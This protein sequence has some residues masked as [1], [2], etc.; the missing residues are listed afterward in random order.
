MRLALLIVCVGPAL[1]IVAARGG[2]G[3]TARI[4]RLSESIP[5]PLAAA[6]S[7]EA[8]IVAVHLAA[9]IL[10][11]PILT[12][13]ATNII[14]SFTRA[15]TH[16]AGFA[17][18]AAGRCLRFVKRLWT[19][20]GLLPPNLAQ[21]ALHACMKATGILPIAPCC[22][23]TFRAFSML[24]AFALTPAFA[25][26]DFTMLLLPAI[27]RAAPL[28]LPAL[29]AVCEQRMPGSLSRRSVTDIARRTRRFLHHQLSLRG[30]LILLASMLGRGALSRN[31][32]L[33]RSM[34]FNL[35]MVPMA[36]E[37]NFYQWLLVP[38]SEEERHRIYARLHERHAP[39]VLDAIYDL[40]GYP[41]RVQTLRLKPSSCILPQSG[42]AA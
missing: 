29:A 26:V 16:F 20:G 3:T 32:G 34:A 37:Y 15:M 33:S 5:P 23:A 19:G 2:R 40:R 1:G 25:T 7:A 42:T 24:L 6:A 21:S 9:R 8:G 27:S 35:K 39:E 10:T 36:V 17:L 12:Q 4:R 14:K 22:T 41:R 28:I 13:T 30:R 31:E 38:A 11:D 18:G